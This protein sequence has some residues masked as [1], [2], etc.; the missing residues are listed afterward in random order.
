ME[1]RTTLDAEDDSEVSDEELEEI[2][3]VR[4]YVSCELDLLDDR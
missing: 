3:E 2:E 4:T 1:K